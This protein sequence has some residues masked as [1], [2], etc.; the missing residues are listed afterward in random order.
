MFGFVLGDSPQP[1]H[2]VHRCWLPQQWQQH[3]SWLGG[4]FI[5][6]TILFGNVVNFLYSPLSVHFQVVEMVRKF[7]LTSAVIFWP[8]GSCIQVAVAVMVSMFFL[9][10]QL[11]HMPFNTRTDNWFQVMALVGLLLVYFMGLLI[12]VQPNLEQRYAF[13]SLLQLVTGAVAAIVLVVPII[14]KA[15][16]R[17][18]ACRGVADRSLSM[19][20]L[21]VL[22][23]LEADYSLMDDEDAALQGSA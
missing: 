22:R 2:R 7:W 11:Y 10:F 5:G 18:G 4:E 21:P 6:L 1:I 17:L 16:L 19:I 14:H 12:K 3:R 8:K 20:E 13:D 23:G 9:G 15:R